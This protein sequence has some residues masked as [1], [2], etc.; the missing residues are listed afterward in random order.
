MALE[1]QLE[2][3]GCFSVAD[4]LVGDGEQLAD[5]VLAALG[6][7]AGVERERERRGV[8]QPPGQL[9]ALPRQRPAALGLVGEVKLHGEAAEQ[10]GAERGVGVGQRGER[11]LAAAR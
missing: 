9:H 11:L 7:V 2:L 5:L 3:R 8:T 6:P 4:D 1:G 10:P